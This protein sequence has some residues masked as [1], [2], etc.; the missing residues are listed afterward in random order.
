MITLNIA[1]QMIEVIEKVAQ[2]NGQSLQDFV[3]IS[4]YEKALQSLIHPEEDELLIDFIQKLPQSKLERSGLDIQK[5]LRDEW[6]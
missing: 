4:A 5:E 6:D 2:K 3:I 1:P